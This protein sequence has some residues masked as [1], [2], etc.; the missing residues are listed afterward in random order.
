MNFLRM[1]IGAS[2]TDEVASIA[3]G[4]FFLSRSSLSP[5]GAL[6]CLFNDSSLTIK[7]TIKPFCYQLS[8]TRAYQEG[9]ASSQSTDDEEEDD[10]VHSASKDFGSNDE[11]LFYINQDLNAML[12]TK[13]DGTRVISWRDIN[14]DEGEM[15]EFVV[16]EDVRA[17][18]VTKFMHTLFKCLY[19]GKYGKLAAGVLEKELR[20]EF[21]SN[22]PWEQQAV[23]SPISLLKGIDAL[24]TNL[25]NV[26]LQDNPRGARPESDLSSVDTFK[27][28]SS[29]PYHILQTGVTLTGKRLY[30]FEAELRVYDNCTDQ[31]CVLVPQD[32]FSI[33]KKGP[34]E[35]L[36]ANTS[37][38]TSVSVPISTAMSP[39]VREDALS[40]IF[41]HSVKD[42]EG[43]SD[44]SLLLHFTSL[45]RLVD[46]E[47]A[48]FKVFNEVAGNQRIAQKGPEK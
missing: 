29:I 47:D 13:S 6:E 30:A 15:L 26:S 34:K 40:F 22:T 32:E 42:S 5:K 8:V 48:F 41:T 25:G 35:Y 4:K 46:F 18:E 23:S 31:F 19:E 28:A 11:R 36:M 10:D 2:P 45:K 3:F 9:E 12:Y 37:P 7:K 14:G 27:D 43:I 17:N 1:F 20:D 33:I 24:S 44:Y 16:D 21:A 38:K 39:F